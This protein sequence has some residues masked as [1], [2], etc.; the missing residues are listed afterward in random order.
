MG[1]TK[2]TAVINHV[3]GPH[4]KKFLKL[5]I[6]DSP[7]SLIVDEATDISNVKYVGVVIKYHSKN[8][9][10]VITTFLSLEVC[11]DSSSFGITEILKKVLNNFDLSTDNMSGLGTDN[12]AVMVGSKNSVYKKLQDLKSKGKLILV[13]CACHSLQ[14]SVGQAV[15]EHF[16]PDLEYL[17]NETY[18]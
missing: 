6:G 16:P 14:L 15:S 7:F 10:R 5:D 11:D 12:A 8:K 18:S 13:P 3:W 4:F 1:R 2:C 17:S 9:C